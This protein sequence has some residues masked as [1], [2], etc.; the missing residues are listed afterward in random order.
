MPPGILY[1]K[2]IQLLLQGQVSG[3]QFL[4][5]KR[6]VCSNTDDVLNLIPDNFRVSGLRQIKVN[7]INRIFKGGGDI[8]SFLINFISVFDSLQKTA[9]LSYELL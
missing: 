2:F 3:G 7:F 5:I 4:L 1:I 9:I 8:R 6:M